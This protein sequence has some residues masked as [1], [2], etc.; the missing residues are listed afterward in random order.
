M[1]TINRKNKNNYN[2]NAKYSNINNKNKVLKKNSIIGKP[3]RKN[4]IINGGANVEAKVET[5][6]LLSAKTYI[7]PFRHPIYSGMFIELA[8]KLKKINNDKDKFMLILNQKT[9]F[10]FYM[11]KPSI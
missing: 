5:T 7:Q 4:T 9:E 2:K 6:K 11:I 1:K 8:K 3:K 10:L